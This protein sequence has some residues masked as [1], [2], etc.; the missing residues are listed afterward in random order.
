[1]GI[2]RR[3]IYTYLLATSERFQ[4]ARRVQ[5]QISFFELVFMSLSFPLKCYEY[6]LA[7]KNFKKMFLV[8][9]FCMWRPRAETNHRHA[10]FQNDK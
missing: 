1:M 8:R 3:V 5:I 10:D 6:E 4:K 2:A 9:T 7:G